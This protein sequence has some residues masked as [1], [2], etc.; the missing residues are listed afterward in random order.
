MKRNGEGRKI[1]NGMGNGIAIS[2]T[3]TEE[4]FELWEE[5]IYSGQE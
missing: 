1:R 4:S 5:T 3:E 2:G